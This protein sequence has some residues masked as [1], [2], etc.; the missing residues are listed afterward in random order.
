[1][2]GHELEVCWVYS[3]NQN[4]QVYNTYDKHLSP[5][6]GYLLKHCLANILSTISNTKFTR[7][8]FEMFSTKFSNINI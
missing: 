5:Y 1:M 7:T 3:F 2:R 4:H 6:S 8:V